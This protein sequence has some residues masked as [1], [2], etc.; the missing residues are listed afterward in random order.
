MNANYQI[1]RSRRMTQAESGNHRVLAT[2]TTHRAAV[3]CDCTEAGMAQLSPLPGTPMGQF[4]YGGERPPVWFAALAA[5][6]CQ[7]AGEGADHD[8]IW[9]CVSGRA[10]YTNSSSEA[11]TIQPLGVQ[12]QGGYTVAVSWLPG[13]TEYKVE[14]YPDPGNSFRV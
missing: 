7:A 10:V 8:V 14:T 2:R 11:E 6:N 3:S 13:E 5:S 9:H 1:N 12:L 4:D